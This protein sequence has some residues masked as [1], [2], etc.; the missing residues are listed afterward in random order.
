IIA[1]VGRQPWAIQDLMPVSVAAS[2][3][4]STSVMVTFFIFLALFTALLAA[5]LSI[6]FKQIKLGPDNEKR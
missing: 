2:R 4:G 3:I 6:M 5:E 1:E